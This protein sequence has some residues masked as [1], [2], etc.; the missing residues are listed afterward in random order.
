MT[1]TFQSSFYPSDSEDVPLPFEIFTDEELEELEQQRE[2]DDWIRSIPT[3][4]DRNP[5]LS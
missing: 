3:P 4:A 2:Q 5:R 1:Y